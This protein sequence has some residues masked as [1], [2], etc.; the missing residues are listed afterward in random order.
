VGLARLL[1]EA[2]GTEKIPHIREKIADM[3][4]HATLL[5]AGFEAAIENANVTPDGFAT[6]NELYTNAAKYYGALHMNEMMT[7]VQDIAGGSILTAPMPGD[8][9]NPETR[10]YIEKYMRTKPEISGEYRTRLFHAARDMTVS[11]AAGHHHVAT[12]MGGGGL[13]AQKLV[14]TMHYDMNHAKELA[15]KAAHLDDPTEG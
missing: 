9:V 4:V 1:A 6:P 14:A 12:L 11:S 13:F 15:R 10:G 8:L 3:I 7:L 5:R 2:N